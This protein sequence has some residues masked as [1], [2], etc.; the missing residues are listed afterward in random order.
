MSLLLHKCRQQN[1]NFDLHAVL[2]RLFSCKTFTLTSHILLLK[3]DSFSLSFENIVE[4]FIIIIM[5]QFPSLMLH[6][7]Q[8]VQD[9]DLG[10]YFRSSVYE[11]VEQFYSN[12]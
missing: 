11:C 7:R 3:N 1:V 8:R 4:F 5:F 2:I 9:D 12:K 6:S 10:E